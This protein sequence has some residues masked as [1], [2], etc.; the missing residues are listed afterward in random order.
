MNPKHPLIQAINTEQ[1]TLL[2]EL[3]VAAQARERLLATAARQRR[4][5]LRRFAYVLAAVAALAIWFLVDHNRPRALTYTSGELH[6][7]AQVGA[8]IA[9]PADATL[10]LHFSD[11]S[12]V[13]LSASTHARVDALGEH[14]AKLLLERGR[15]S[16]TVIRHAQRRWHLRAG[17]F[18]VAVTGTR[19]EVG[20]NPQREQFEVHTLE[21]RV[22]VS[23]QPI[24]TRS[25]SAG[26]ILRVER[27][28]GQYHFVETDVATSS[29]AM[30]SVE[31]TPSNLPDPASGAAGPSG[32]PP[33]GA[34]PSVPDSALGAHTSAL[35][36]KGAQT[37]QSAAAGPSWRGLA[38]S[39]QYKAALTQA[40]TEGFEALC[41]SSNASDLIALSEVARLAGNVERARLSLN[42]IRQRFQGQSAAAVA[43]YTLGRMAFDGSRDYASAARWFQTYL[44]EQGQGSLAREAAGRL[45]EALERAGNHAAAERAARQY[46]DRYPDGP[47][48]GL[49]RR[50]LG[51]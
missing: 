50:I 44:S 4:P 16:V 30:P 17:P 36:V 37:S 18:D 15:V 42:S 23:G 48:K 27:V 26:E 13:V 24:A 21:G 22:E 28:D 34:A 25:V 49:A 35:S 38:K 51:E 20:W 43:A 5:L 1:D 11:Q 10:P 9:A 29:S 19:F 6:A 7:A 32:E 47:Q 39:G 46:L 40:E 33:V 3:H 14:E 41:Q 2:D 45:I 12:E 8:F 31:P